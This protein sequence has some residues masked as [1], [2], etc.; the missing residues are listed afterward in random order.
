[1]PSKSKSSD[2]VKHAARS[3]I[4][5]TSRDKQ[6]L[7]E[8][9]AEATA[10][11]SEPRADLTALAEELKRAVV[12]QPHEIPEDVITMDTRAEILDVDTGETTT[13]TLVFPSRANIDDGKISVIA[14]IGAGMLGYR[15]GD[16]FEWRVPAGIRRMRVTKIHFQPEAAGGRFAV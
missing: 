6:L 9:I 8:L 10:L 2:A 12:V 15:T 5:I 3:P 1:M 4:H 16:E 13:F 11:R 14:P 7:E